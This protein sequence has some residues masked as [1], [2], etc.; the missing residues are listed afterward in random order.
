MKI[1]EPGPS[2][3]FACSS[4]LAPPSSIFSHP[5]SLRRPHPSILGL[6]SSVLSLLSSVFAPHSSIFVPHSSLLTL[7]FG[8][9]ESPTEARNMGSVPLF[10]F[11][12]AFPK[13]VSVPDS[14]AAL[15]P[16]GVHQ[17]QW[18]GPT[19]SG[20]V[21]PGGHLVAGPTR[22]PARGSAKR[23]SEAFL[24]SATAACSLLP[25][26]ARHLLAIWCV[27]IPDP[28]GPCP[29]R[30]GAPSSFGSAGR[31]PSGPVSKDAT[32]AGTRR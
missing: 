23:V 28:C 9:A 12:Y 14:P 17:E 18:T 10:R 21:P 2:S 24:S 20:S 1:E 31:Q 16:V 32:R 15:D 11:S 3:R 30:L 4:V 8:F 29:G 25:E 22:Y 7:I 5:S 26:N 13:T 6:R 19:P 27:S